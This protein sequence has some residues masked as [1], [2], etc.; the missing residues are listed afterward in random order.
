ML[1]VREI[2]LSKG[3]RAMENLGGK[4]MWC[5]ILLKRLF[6]KSFLVMSH[7]KRDQ[8]KSKGPASAKALR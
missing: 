3:I 8:K 6:K 7:W 4:A 1:R 5:N 2:S